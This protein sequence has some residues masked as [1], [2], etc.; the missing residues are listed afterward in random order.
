MVDDH[1]KRLCE[2]FQLE[3]P[4]VGEDKS[5][6]LH[7]EGVC[8]RIVPFETGAR[9][10]SRV[11]PLPQRNTEALLMRA[12]KANFLG[13]GTGDAVLGINEE[14]TFL[15]LSLDLTAQISYNAF[16]EK[17]ETLANYTDYWK[18]QVKSCDEELH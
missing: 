8:L 14:E 18:Q 16:K 11:A 12:M 3:L 5:R 2:E 1:L 9:L 13:Q 7:L 17:I 10:T 15:T 4:R 6:E